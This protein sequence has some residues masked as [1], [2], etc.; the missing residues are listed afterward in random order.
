MLNLGSP[1]RHQPL[2]RAFTLGD[3]QEVKVMALDDPELWPL[4]KTDA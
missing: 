1:C 3:S 4:F 2:Q